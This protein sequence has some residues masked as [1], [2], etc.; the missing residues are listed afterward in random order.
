MIVVALVLAA[1]CVYLWASLVVLRR[2]L[3]DFVGR[4]DELVNGCIRLEDRVDKLESRID[5]IQHLA[6]QA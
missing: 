6:M 4:H 2:Y 1:F 5:E 3:T